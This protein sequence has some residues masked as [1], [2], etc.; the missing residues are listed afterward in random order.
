MNQP[1]MPD[2]HL[3]ATDPLA[4]PGRRVLVL[5]LGISG[6]AAVRY[7]LHCQAQVTVVDTRAQPPALT[8]LRER[9]PDVPFASCALEAVDLADVDVVIWSPGLSIEVGAA[10]ALAERIRAAGI[11][12]TGELDLFMMAR[13]RHAG[14]TTVI[15]ITGTNGKTTVC[16]LSTLM[17]QAC[18][19]HAVAVGNIGITMLDAWCDALAD[20]TMPRLW[21]VELSSFQL[22]LSHGFDP[23]VATILNITPDHSD[24]HAS[25]DSYRA[26]KHRII[27]PSTLF[28]APADVA[29]PASASASRIRRF[30]LD[31]PVGVGDTGLI[32]EGGLVW[33]GQAQAAEA[34]PVRRRGEVVAPPVRRRLMPVEA[35]R[36]RGVHNQLNALAALAL[37]SA[38]DLPMAPML[39][40]LR[41]YR[42]E[43][44]RC[45]LVARIDEVEYYDDSKGTNVG[46]TCAALAGLGRKAWLI[47]GGVGK[48][49]DFSPLLA[50][51]RA[52]AA[53]VILI[54]A[55]AV[56]IDEAIRP[57]GVPCEHAVDLAQ[58][59]ERAAELARP[60]QAV[61]LSPACASFDMFRDYRHRGEVFIDL[62]R[63]L[64]EA[65]GQPMELTC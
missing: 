39:H 38:L 48:D 42:G 23:D 4:E 34:E 9:Y 30:G 7:A 22:A 57:A 27:G 28:V 44:H 18:G 3:I 16:A 5:G 1:L 58:A 54:G 64:G 31:E 21:F 52:H 24:W 49:Q 62:V 59:L 37:C 13:A 32:H 56:R 12:L 41:D 36:I 46:S 2:T 40:A 8:R 14:D 33:L 60:G 55:D 26:A 29:A 10:A 51:V 47:A 11:I 50:P 19:V 15:A 63:Q 35:M 53:G 43:A 20:Q 65:R 45:Q 17:A 6:L 25:F 61:L